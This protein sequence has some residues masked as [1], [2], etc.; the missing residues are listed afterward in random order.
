M[1]S[2]LFVCLGNICRSPIAD[3]IANKIAK[4][5]NLDLYIDSAGTSDFHKGSS[6]CE[7][8]QKVASKYGVNISGLKSRPIVPK[9]LEEFEIIVAMDEQN[10]KDL[11][12]YGFKN[13]Y[14]LGEFADLE[15]KDVPDPY[16]YRGFKGFEL[17]YEM[18]EK[19]VKDLLRD[20]I[21]DK[22]NA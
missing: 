22:L 11:L 17:V 5:E 7:N 3:G 21:N 4:E 9:D 2:I 20:T 18:I 6:P 19:G 1:K 15:N 13:V 8:S 12:H 14:K 16:Y 10:K